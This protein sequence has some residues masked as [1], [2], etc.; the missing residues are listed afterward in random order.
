M[1]TNDTRKEIMKKQHQPNPNPQVEAI[2]QAY[3]KTHLTDVQFEDLVTQTITDAEKRG[4]ETGGGRTYDQGFS[5]GYDQGMSE[6]YDTCA[7]E[8]GLDTASS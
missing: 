7:A 1:K 6:G 8:N 3:L 5:D 2:V 4:A